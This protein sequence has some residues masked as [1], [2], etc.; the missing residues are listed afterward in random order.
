LVEY[1]FLNKKGKK[2]KKSLI[3]LAICLFSSS[4][5]AGSC[6]MLAGKVDS[7]IKAAQKLHDEGMAA[8]SSGNHAK[9][10]ELLKKALGLFKG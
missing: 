8:H 1:G 3:V 10:E 5:F 2:M 6:P 9:S 4:A 7:K